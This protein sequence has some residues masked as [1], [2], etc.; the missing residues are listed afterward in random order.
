MVLIELI[1]QSRQGHVI[2]SKN[3]KNWEVESGFIE[4]KPKK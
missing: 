3:F 1:T 4:D 2:T